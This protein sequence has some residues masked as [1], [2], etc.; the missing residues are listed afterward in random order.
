MTNNANG[1]ETLINRIL[2]LNPNADKTNL[3][4]LTTAELQ[5]RLINSQQRRIADLQPSSTVGTDLGG[6]RDDVIN[7]LMSGGGFSQQA[8]NS[9]TDQELMDAL[10]ERDTYGREYNR[11]TQDRKDSLADFGTQLSM[12]TGSK[13]R[14]AEQQGRVAQNLE[15]TRGLAGMMNNF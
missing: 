8:L 9:F 4:K 15:R 2:R 12:L 7:E 11:R 10:R 3:E 6:R 14:Q 5:Q 1:N 13:Q